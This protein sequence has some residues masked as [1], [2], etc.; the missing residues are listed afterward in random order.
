M[1]DHKIPVVAIAP[2]AL[3]GEDTNMTLIDQDLLA[4]NIPFVAISHVWSDGLGNQGRNA[5]PKCQLRRIQTWVNGL[6]QNDAEPVP[7]WIDSLSIPENKD[8]RS[9]EAKTKAIAG[10][11]NICE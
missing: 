8:E 7:F 4:P 6:Y 1:D 2:I 9:R 11:H 5:L 3:S 10:T